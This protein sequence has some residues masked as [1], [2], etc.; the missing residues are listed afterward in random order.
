MGTTIH[1]FI[2]IF[3]SKFKI[4][5]ETVK[6]NKIVIPI[7]QRDY[8]Q[9]RTSHA[10]NRVRERFLNA[11]KSAIC[12]TPITLDFIYG[13]I[14][15]N[16]IM[17][18][19]D[20]QQRLTTLFL[21]HYYIAKKENIM[22]A[23]VCCLKNF[24]YETRYSARD[25]CDFLIRE[26]NPSFTNS[27]S[28]EIENHAKFPLDW[29]KDATI[30]SMMKMLDS[31]DEV[32][33]NETDVWEK[34][35]DGA[36]SFYFLPIRDMGLTDEL[37][38]KMNSRGKPLTQFEHFKAEFEQELRKIDEKSAKRIGNKIDRDWTDMLWF[39]R[40]EENI[41]DNEFLRYFSYI[42]AIICY[43]NGGTMQGKSSDEFDLLKQ[44]FSVDTQ[45]AKE[46]INTLEL[47]FDCWCKIDEYAN[48]KDFFEKFFSYT[49]EEN[50]IKI[51][52]RY[53]LD[54]FN[55][56]L[57]NNYESG[58][59]NRLFPLNR[60][61]LLYSVIQYLLNKENIT[62]IQFARRLRV[63]NNL[64]VNSEDELS[65]SE[66]R[67]SGNRMPAIL[68][69]VK[70]IIVTGQI[71]TSIEK[72]FNRY[73]LSEER[74]KIQWTINNSDKA[75]CLFELEDHPLLDGQIG[76]IGLNNLHLYNRFQSLYDCDYDK[77]D[78]ALM[79][80]GFYGQTE[81]NRRRYQVGSGTRRN[82]TSWKSL[83]H[84]S[85]NI[86]FENT[87]KI[88]LALLSM[89]ETFSDEKLATIA[90]NYMAECE[91][92]SLFDWRYY[93][94][95]YP[96]FRPKSY[97]KLWWEDMANNPYEIYILQT[98]TNWSENTY[99]PFLKEVDEAN[100]SRDYCGQY[101]NRGDDWYECTNCAFIMTQDIDGKDTEIDRLTILQND[102]GIDIENRIEKFRAYMSQK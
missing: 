91:N 13:D 51:D 60:I 18:P 96:V 61:V 41:I 75:E 76:I 81:A 63:V 78:C 30:S 15:S 5:E 40:D 73:Q 79:S 46:N 23:D 37:Y 38:I 82:E 68:K 66:L 97:G 95:K 52:K 16:G 90:N 17:T 98:K 29:K 56:C 43:E 67:T 7:I 99:S 65:D 45:N 94:I 59:R 20:G 80:I 35:K 100:L 64:I 28:K 34:L 21:L 84:R 31:I 4:G 50:K 55:D 77:I 83:F 47:F 32:F 26:F 10:V 86:G 53:D 70:H 22:D 12:E 89:Y 49:H 14:D 93:Y 72:N 25:F 3:N 27:I 9:G 85:S 54:I 33:A 101:I 57:K 24:S 2:D 69:Q 36:I 92:N 11:L 6:L 58:G 8:A 88:L 1:N 74:E 62:E 102:D 42:C 87:S 71:N 39:Y 19:L 48:P 44:F